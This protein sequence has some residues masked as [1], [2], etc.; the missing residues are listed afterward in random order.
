MYKIYENYYALIVATASKYLA[1][2][3]AKCRSKGMTLSE[4][5]DDWEKWDEVLLKPFRHGAYKTV[6]M[7]TA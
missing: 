4:A 6:N 2:H 7:L 3:L 5:L 1:E